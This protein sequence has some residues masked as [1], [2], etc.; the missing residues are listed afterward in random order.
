MYVC[1]SLCAFVLVWISN[2]L[3][4]VNTYGWLSDSVYN[5]AAAS[6]LHRCDVCVCVCVCMVSGI[7]ILTVFHI[8]EGETSECYCKR[9]TSCP[10]SKNLSLFLSVSPSLTYSHIHTNTHT[11]THT[12]IL[13]SKICFL[14]LSILPLS[15]FSPLLSISLCFSLFL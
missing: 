2:C 8:R 3:K 13:T 10:I 5:T 15:I 1:V 12:E 6:Y 9:S 4:S 7:E 11:N 14:F